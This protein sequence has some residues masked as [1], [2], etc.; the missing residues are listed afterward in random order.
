MSM[1]SCLWTL[2]VLGTALV[3]VRAPASE[4]P[5]DLRRLA[6]HVASGVAAIGDVH[7]GPRGRRILILEE[8]HDSRALQIESAICLVR[9]HEQA[10]LRDIALEGYLLEEKPITTDWYSETAGSLAA[11]ARVAVQLLKEGE[12]SCAEFAALVYDD[13]RLYPIDR[14][15]DHPAEPDVKSQ[16]APTMYL[17][18]LGEANLDQNDARNQEL[19]NELS[20]II[21]AFKE[22]DRS[23][24]KTR[25][26][27]KRVEMREKLTEYYDYVTS[28]DPWARKTMEA[29]RADTNW[30]LSER[31]ELYREIERRAG[32]AH[33]PLRD[34]DKEA[35]RSLLEW[36]E[37]RHRASKAMTAETGKIA[38]AGG[39]GPVAMILGT[40]HTK[41]VVDVFGHEDRPWVTIRPN[42]R[43]GNRG[44]IAM[45]M[46][47][48]KGERLSLYSD[49]IVATLINEFGTREMKP[50]PVL[51]QPWFQAKAELYLL[52]DRMTHAMLGPPGPPRG[53]GPPFGLSG[54]DFSG[55]WVAIDPSRIR[56]SGYNSGGR[57]YRI[58]DLSLEQ[59]RQAGL[60][61]GVLT[62]LGALKGREYSAEKTFLAAVAGSIGESALAEHKQ[63]ILGAAEVKAIIFPVVLNHQIPS[64]R[65]EIW[66]KASLSREA[67]SAEERSDVESMLKDAL[68][69]VD[70]VG[71]LNTTKVEDKAG[72]VQLSLDTIA[73]FDVSAEGA[74]G[75]SLGI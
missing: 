23:G 28:H 3:P 44:D 71:M 34:E 18:R 52:V 58:T 50:R 68:A 74:A 53:G 45:S 13:C 11:R 60:A 33:A 22:A 21:A 36:F 10:Q 56:L 65:K 69:E 17:V 49:G 42:A 20:V 12:I 41:D 31:I 6:E 14:Q 59:L 26:E 73:G 70:N 30:V 35:M 29:I 24:E 19:L 27:E 15:A 61:P 40:A 1:K 16:N 5:L 4:Q 25:V 9:L 55:Q 57:L 38:D 48:R 2:A 62:G 54:A 32:R 67:V 75:I 47:S 43:S 63:A 64:R 37:A 72:R 51:M 66:V 7:D 8:R 46:Y 39:S